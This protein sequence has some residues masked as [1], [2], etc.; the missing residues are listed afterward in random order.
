MYTVF[1]FEAHT[2]A[3]MELSK[4]KPCDWPNTENPY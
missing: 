1:T 3:K 2:R 4:P